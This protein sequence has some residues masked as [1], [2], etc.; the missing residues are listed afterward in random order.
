[1]KVIFPPWGELKGGF[2]IGCTHLV[3]FRYA[4]STPLLLPCLREAASAKQGRHLPQGRRFT[5]VSAY[6]NPSRAVFYL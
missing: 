5:T 4:C 3:Q 6:H 2:L 1:M